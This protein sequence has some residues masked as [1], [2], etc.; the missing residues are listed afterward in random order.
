MRALGALTAHF[1]VI[2]TAL[3]VTTSFFSG[4]LSKA[5]QSNEPRLGR[6]I[7]DFVLR[8]A[9]NGEQWKLSEQYEQAKVVVLYFNS[10][11]CPVTNRYLP[12]L[13]K[14]RAR[15]VDEG[16]IFVT[17]NS[18]QHESTEDIRQHAR[19]YELQIPALHDAKGDVARSL[20][21]TRTSEAI[22]LERDLTMRYRG[23]I[24]DRYERGVTRPKADTNFLHDAIQAVLNGTAVKIS[25]TEV[26]ACPLNLAPVE[27]VSESPEHITYAEHAAA[28][29]QR[30]CQACHRPDGIGPFKLMTYEDAK[31]WA[32]SIR[33]VVTQGLMPPWHAEAPH[34]HFSNDR[35]LTEEERA[36]LLGWIDDGTMQ[37][38]TKMLPAQRTYS[39]SWSIGTPDLVVSMDK[40][41]SVPAETPKLG[42]P[43]KY[44]WG[45]KAFRRES[46]VTAAEVRPGAAEVV[47]H[48]SV[49]I[50][51]EGVS[52]KLVGDE[53][54]GGLLGD[55][56]SPIND[57]PHLVSFVPGDNA[58]VRRE[59][60]A[61][62]IPK[63]ARL[64]FE[65][66]YTP[67]GK[68][69]TDRTQVGLRF[70]LKPPTHEVLSTAVINYWFSIPPG[71]S[72]HRVRAKTGRFK[73]DSVLLTMNPHMHYRGKSFK[74][75]LVRP[76]GTRSLLL[77]VPNYNFEWQT[78]Y[79][80]A[81]PISIPKGS[82]IECTATFDNSQANPF[83]PDPT[84]RV[85]WG[86]QTWEEMMLGGFEVYEE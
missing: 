67:T 3:V 7:E 48:A 65:M 54:P 46:W 21:V 10:T 36:M 47:H 26:E 81:K 53:L 33:E 25:I 80:L 52:I 8:N 44:I 5:E 51:P 6:K 83:N 30:R 16:V 38:N 74:Y 39:D 13:E 45:G 24:D 18:N 2:A 43:Y 41:V 76:S 58:F 49:Y 34:G 4:S 57:L 17:I 62:R 35:S 61:M 42:V 22:V 23:A 71:A 29:I 28:I 79:V 12:S 59:G 78:T 9:I 63:G 15:F 68:A 86:E 69:A 84:V 14:L 20:A 82:R 19:E 40:P 32:A 60:L 31:A 75:E 66:H 1:K 72:N 85:T 77:H 50:V 11:E 55:L 37:G 64:L 73:R 27:A 70:A 56:T